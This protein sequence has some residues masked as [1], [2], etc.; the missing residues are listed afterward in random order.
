M[1]KIALALIALQVT[2]VVFMMACKSGKKEPTAVS[3][4]SPAPDTTAL[5]FL[6]GVV[7]G[8]TLDFNAVFFPGGNTFYFT[9]SLNKKLT[10]LES[11]FENGQWSQPVISPAFDTAFSN[12]DPFIASDTS[13]YFISNRATSAS[14][15]IKDYDIY[16]MTWKDGKYSAAERLPEVNSDS[17]EYYVSL[18]KNGNIYFSSYRD[19]NLDLYMAQKQGDHYLTPLNM[20]AVINSVSDE[21]DPFVA[22]DESYLIYAS[23]RPGGL[24]EADLYISVRKNGQWQAPVNMGKRINTSTY[25]YCPNLTPDGKYFFFSSER[26]VKWISAEVLRSY[27]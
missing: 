22:P 21:H 10:V 20:G 14:D 3:Y 24:G 4:P 25:E 15:T 9:R 18:S 6:P 17:T 13:M 27:K 19:G 23:D 16:R 1:K 11:R 8:D 7:S 5:T 2:G 12:V 26:N